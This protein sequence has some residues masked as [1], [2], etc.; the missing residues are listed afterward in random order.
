MGGSTIEENQTTYIAIQIK[1]LTGLLQQLFLTYVLGKE[2][3]KRQ[4]GIPLRSA[5]TEIYSLRWS[6]KKS[7]GKMRLD[8]LFTV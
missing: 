3:Y 1:A 6:P 2:M 7:V 4:L 5:V 8:F